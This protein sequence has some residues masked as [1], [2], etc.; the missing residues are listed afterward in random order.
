MSPADPTILVVDDDEIVLS[1]LELL[2]GFE[3]GHRV[4][5]FTSPG[6][7]LAALEDHPVD[8]AVSDFL[9]PEMNGVEFLLEVK[10]RQPEALRVLLTGYADKD[11]AINAINEVGLYQY[12]E[13][14]WDNDA[15]LLLVRNALQLRSETAQRKLEHQQL[16]QAE[17]MATLG[18]L[19]SGMAHEINNPNNFILLNAKIIA[20]V[21]DDLAPLI[22][23]EA[24]QGLNLAGMPNSERTRDKVGQL[25]SGCVEGAQRIQ[26]IVQELKNFS[27]QDPGDL[28]Q[29]V[30]INAVVES[31]LLIT[32]NLIKRSTDNLTVNQGD[33]IPALQGNA[34]QLEQVLINLLTNACEAL[35]DRAQGITID[36]GLDADAGAVV[37]TVQDEGAGIASEHLQRIVDPFFTTKR[38]SGGTGLGL[39]ISYNIV[40]AHGGELG[41]SST[42][43]GGTQ[44]TLTLPLPRADT[45]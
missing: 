38:S 16:L 41:F 2:L 1:A 44:A 33:A 18:T 39:S 12:I 14:P 43:E 7:A 10:H 31:A 29:P 6:E 23:G 32:R 25:I 17:K 35:S 8:L 42:P 13:K 5:S 20:R 4:I 19:A 27:R 34:Q 21:W 11:S 36:T 30:A 3:E 45:R 28:N 22:G 40:K 37:V 9:M 24:G 26:K 15:L